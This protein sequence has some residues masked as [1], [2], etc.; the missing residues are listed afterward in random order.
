M[1]AGR[2]TGAECRVLAADE[3]EIA[4]PVDL[5]VVDRARAIAEAD[6]CPQIEIDLAPAIGGL[7]LKRPAPPPLVDRKRPSPL[8]P[9]R[10]VDRG[11]ALRRLREAKG[12]VAADRC[13]DRND[14]GEGECARLVHDVLSSY[15]GPL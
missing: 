7:A 10:P 1:G 15:V 5:L 3:I 12:R 8:G 4:D 9:D 6:L 14:S 13:D 2:P 11:D